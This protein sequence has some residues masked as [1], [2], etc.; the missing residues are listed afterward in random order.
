M[1][2]PGDSARG[3]LVE[4]PVEIDPDSVSASY[5]K[6]VLTV[7]LPKPAEAQRQARTIPI[8]TS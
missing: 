8:T 4:L 3:V 7:A 5:Q 1:R 2:L 6:G